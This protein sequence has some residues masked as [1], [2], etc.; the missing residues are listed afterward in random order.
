VV[1]NALEKSNVQAVREMNRMI[2]ITRAYTNVSTMQQR[3]DELRR[4]AIEKLA[5]V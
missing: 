4:K 2:E 3:T 1:Q 5:E